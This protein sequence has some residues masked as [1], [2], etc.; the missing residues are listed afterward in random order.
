ML[1]IQT[2]KDKKVLVIL[3]KTIKHKAKLIKSMKT[4]RSLTFVQPHQFTLTW[5]MT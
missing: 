5:C 3:I 1:K 4:T 2:L